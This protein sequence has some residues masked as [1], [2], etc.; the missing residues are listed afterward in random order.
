MPLVRLLDR[1]PPAL[2][3]AL[4]LSL[5]TG[6]L[7]TTA[8]WTPRCCL[9]TQAVTKPPTPHAR[10]SSNAGLDR[11]VVAHLLVATS[12]TAEDGCYWNSGRA[13]LGRC[14]R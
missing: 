11:C 12:A 13:P 10:A 14:A 1:R 5:D 3:G 2:S 4:L 9:R 6:S 7:A 8:A